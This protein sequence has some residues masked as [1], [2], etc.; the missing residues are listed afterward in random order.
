[1]NS[2]ITIDSAPFGLDLQL[3]VIEEGKVAALRFPCRREGSRWIASDTE[4]PVV[5]QPTHWRQWRNGTSL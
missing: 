3:A 5:V 1:M 2:W 4:R